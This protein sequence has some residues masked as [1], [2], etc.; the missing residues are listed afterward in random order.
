MCAEVGNRDRRRGLEVRVW[1]GRKHCQVRTG[2]ESIPSSTGSLTVPL[3]NPGLSSQ[4]RCLDRTL[5]A[6]S[7]SSQDRRVD[8]NQ[9]KQSNKTQTNKTDC[10]CH[11]NC[12][13]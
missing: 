13:S 2:D 5:G 3:G 12:D 4:D 9:I 1:A 8:R 11:L 10:L 7:L 6:D